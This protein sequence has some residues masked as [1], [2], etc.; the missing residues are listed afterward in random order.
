MYITYPAGYETFLLLFQ[1]VIKCN[2]SD[3]C[4]FECEFSSVMYIVF[5]IL[6]RKL[7][8][9]LSHKQNEKQNRKVN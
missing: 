8:V 4:V 9:R 1:S 3:V 7:K 5:P 6:L 2:R